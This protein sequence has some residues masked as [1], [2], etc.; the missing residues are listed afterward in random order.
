MIE[1]IKKIFNKRVILYLIF[2]V[3]TTVINFIVFYYT[4]SIL[5]IN[6][7][8]A[9]VIAWIIAV[10]FAFITNKYIVF[11]SK[12]NETK[13]FFKEMLSFFSSRLFTLLLEEAILFIFI[14]IAK[15][16]ANIIK[17]IAQ[18]LVIIFNYILSKFFVFNNK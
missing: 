14:T 13:L 2:G 16:D 18:V 9:N 12:N 10:I 4:N 8:I 17:L 1:K 3:L 6:E 15:F 5:I 11:E 7:L